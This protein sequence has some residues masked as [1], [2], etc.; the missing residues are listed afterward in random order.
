MTFQT[1]ITLR[2]ALPADAPFL[3]RMIDI[4]GEGIPTWL[5]RQSAQAGES[6]LDVGAQ[7]ARRAQGGFSYTNALIA[8]F[9]GRPAGMMLGYVIGEPSDAEH[10]E[11]AG[12]PAAIRPF[13]EL[14]HEAPG[15]FY[16]NAL[17][18]RPGLRGHGIGTALMRAAQ[19]RAAAAGASE[20]SIQVFSQNTDALRLYERLGYR[21]VAS[22]PVLDHPCQPYYDADVLLLT[23]S[24]A[25]D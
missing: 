13:V 22:R 12:L 4:A 19:E 14:E 5:W 3:A 16:V 1:R 23:R 17:A 21:T 2:G 11:I 7:R 9:A 24:A 25:R 6:A 20:L 15:S 18:V 8:E 10:A